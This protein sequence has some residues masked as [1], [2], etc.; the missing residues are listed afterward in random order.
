MHWLIFLIQVSQF[1]ECVKGVKSEVELFT[2][3]NTI[4]SIQDKFQN[5]LKDVLDFVLNTEESLVNLAIG[6]FLCS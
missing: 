4:T 2:L 5:T 6:S 3:I 1:Y